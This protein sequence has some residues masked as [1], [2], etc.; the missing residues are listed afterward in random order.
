MA[1]L[2]DLVEAHI[3]ESAHWQ[4]VDYNGHSAE[5]PFKPVDQ[6]WLSVPTAGKLDPQ[7]EGNWMVR[8]VKSPVIVEISDGKRTK[9]VTTNCLHRR[10]QPEVNSLPGIIPNP[11]TW[12]SNSSQSWQPP[13]IDSVHHKQREDALLE[14]DTH[15][16]DLGTE[17]R[18]RGW[19]V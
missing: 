12:A 15:Q 10:I 11:A 17:L 1:E 13:G 5:W 9:V 16:T 3:V 18:K 2:Q 7:W 4:K 8:R 14:T 19:R 6:V